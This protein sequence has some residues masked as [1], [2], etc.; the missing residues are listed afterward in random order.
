MPNMVSVRPRCMASE[1]CF[2]S[3]LLVVIIIIITIIIIIKN[4]L[5]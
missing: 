1:V 4:V 3:V 2:M 5:T